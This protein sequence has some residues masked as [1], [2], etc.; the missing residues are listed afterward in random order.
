MD[1]TLKHIWQE[2][3]QIFKDNLDEET[4]KSLFLSIKPADFDNNTLTLQL[5]SLF[6]YEYLEEN[7]LDLIKKTLKR[8]IGSNAKLE[9]KV[10]VDN[11]TAPKNPQKSSVRLMGNSSSSAQ[12]NNPIDIKTKNTPKNPFIIPGIQKVK[13]KSQLKKEFNF[14]TFVEGKANTVGVQ[15]G[16]K[17]AERPEEKQFNPLFLHAPTGLGKTHLAHAIGLY[18]KEKNPERIILYR[19]SHFFQSAYTKAV[20][21]KDVNNFINFYQNVDIFILDDIQDLT[22]S[23]GTQ[24][25]LFQIFNYLHTKGKQLIL[26]ADRPPVD[27]TGFFD[28]LSTR[29]KWGVITEMQM[30]DYKTRLE[31]LKRK[32]LIHGYKV[33]DDILDLLANSITSSIR[34]LEGTLLSLIALATAYNTKINIDLTKKILKDI[35]KHKNPEYSIA[36]IINIV[37]K[38]FNISEK[39]IKARTRKREVVTARHLA[40]FFCQKLTN[41]SL[42]AIGAEFGGRDHSTVVHASK[43]VKNLNETDKDFRRSMEDIQRL[44]KY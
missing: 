21:E 40:M 39:A 43:T 15:I 7:Y 17:I 19:S 32:T 22:S 5:P 16:K 27:L 2:C 9:Y 28:R 26:C 8:V 18:A 13:I 23:N 35:I 31:I 38:Y 36:Q 12:E 37:S 6:V 10:T 25:I 14:D 44:L 30:P 3:L 4:Y 20:R 29:F 42:S 34:E 24:K 11:T 33:S 41:K 1:K